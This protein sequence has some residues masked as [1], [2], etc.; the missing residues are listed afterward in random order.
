MHEKRKAM[1]VSKIKVN[2]VKSYE[3]RALEDMMKDFN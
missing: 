3:L 2:Q 1:I